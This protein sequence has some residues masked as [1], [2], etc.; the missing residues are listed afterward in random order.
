MY[1]GSVQPIPKTCL[2]SINRLI[3]KFLWSDKTEQINRTTLTL[4]K[5][6]GGLGITDLEIKLPALHLNGYQ[7]LH[8]LWVP[9]TRYWI[10]Q[11]L[12]RFHPAW[13]SLGSNNKPHF[14]PLNPFPPPPPDLLL[15]FPGEPRKTEIEN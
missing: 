14:D 10:G 3:F 12:S 9:F 2:Q 1:L 7:P 15:L 6:R 8:A 5:D 4:P 11:K 13:S